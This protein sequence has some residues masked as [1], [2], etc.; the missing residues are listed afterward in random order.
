MSKTSLRKK[1]RTMKLPWLILLGYGLSSPLM[2]AVEEIRIT[3]GADDAEETS[4]GDMKLGSSDIDFMYSHGGNRQG[5]NQT[6]GLR[7]KNINIPKGATVTNAY[8]QLKADEP[9]SKA[10]TLSIQGQSVDNAPAFTSASKNISTRSKTGAT[11]SWSPVPWSNVGQTGA[12]QRTPNIASVI[13]EIVN[14]VGW[15]QGNS[16]A[17]I[18]SGTGKRAAESFDSDQRGAA[19]LHVEYAI[20]TE[21]PPETEAQ[22][23]EPL[24]VPVDHDTRTTSAGTLRFPRIGGM[25]IGAS[26]YDDLQ[27]RNGLAKLD[28]AILSLGIDWNRG[29]MT[30]SDLISDLKSQNPDILI[31]QITMIQEVPKSNGGWALRDVFDKVSGEQGPGGQGDW[32]AR[33]INGNNI[34]AF[35]GTW[36]INISPFVTPDRNGDKFP[37][38]FA[39]RNTEVLFTDTDFDIIYL[40]GFEP[41]PRPQEGKADWDS[42]GRTDDDDDPAVKKWYR[43]A[44]AEYAHSIRALNPGKLIMSNVISWVNPSPWRG[45]F[46]QFQGLLDGGFVEHAIGE[47]WSIETWGSWTTLLENY[48]KTTDHMKGPKIMLFET[49][50]KSQNYGLMRYGLATALLGDGMFGYSDIANE[51]NSALWFDEYDLAGTASTGWLGKATEPRQV[52]PWKN[53]IYRRKFQNGMVLVFPK[54]PN[55]RHNDVTEKRTV[56]I[57]PGYHRINGNQDPS[58]NNGQSVSTITLKERNGIILVRDGF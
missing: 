10:T 33:D 42:D 51:Y 24:P 6:V 17:I 30:A 38:W 15:T 56:T 40:D 53:G 50:G 48:H 9:G 4:L 34:T 19:L 16:V 12:R 14:R 57:E 36:S 58:I 22:P 41:K 8:I 54:Q 13:Q 35:P 2:A 1:T 5:G 21:P 44:M 31:G 27:A 18:F 28:L 55:D 45:P 3:A 43:D 46:R 23:P 37:T 11:V 26:N 25:N 7:F 39:K 47:S 29:G 52:T 32:F 49:I 20:N